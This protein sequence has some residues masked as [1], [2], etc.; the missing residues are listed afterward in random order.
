MSTLAEDISVA[1][2]SSRGVSKIARAL[3]CRLCAMYSYPPRGKPV[4]LKEYNSLTIMVEKDAPVAQ[5][6]ERQPCK[7]LIAGPT[8]ARGFKSSARGTK[9]VL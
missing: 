9:H 2:P 8:P 1:G 6:L 3:H 7:L 5:W 4:Y